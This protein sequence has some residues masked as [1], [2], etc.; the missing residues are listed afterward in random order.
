MALSRASSDPT[1][2]PSML[3]PHQLPID[4]IGDLNGNV[5]TK[6]LSFKA[7]PLT[8]ASRSYDAALPAGLRCGVV[9]SNWD[10]DYQAATG[11]PAPW[12]I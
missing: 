4:R 5:D 9:P 7:V 12:Q 3:R 8:A 1:A 11:R 10:S 2:C 6:N